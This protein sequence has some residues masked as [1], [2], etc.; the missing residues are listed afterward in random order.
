MKMKVLA[1]IVFATCCIIMVIPL[2]A[3]LEVAG[4]PPWYGWL[5]ILALC[6]S[7]NILAETKHW[8]EKKE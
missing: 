5:W 8:R 7:I 4:F 6:I 1:F 2:W 3:V